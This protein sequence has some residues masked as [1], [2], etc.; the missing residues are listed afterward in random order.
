MIFHKYKNIILSC[1][2]AFTGHAFTSHVN[3]KNAGEGNAFSNNIMASQ[4]SFRGIYDV[5]PV[6]LKKKNLPFTK[7]GKLSQ[8]SGEIAQERK[9]PESNPYL[10]LLF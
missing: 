9:I 5:L 4:N 2:R 6:N 3:I 10:S 1:I 8:P 7:N